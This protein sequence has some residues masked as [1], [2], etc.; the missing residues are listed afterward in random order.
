VFFTVKQQTESYCRERFGKFTSIRNS[1]LQF[2]I[3]LIDKIA[4]RM[5]QRDQQLDVVLKLKPRTTFLCDLKSVQFQV[6]REALRYF[7][8]VLQNPHDQITAYMC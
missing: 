8:T 2:K 1:G 5:N 4:G 3:P 6:R 7:F